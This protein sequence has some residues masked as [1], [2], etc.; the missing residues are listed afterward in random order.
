VAKCCDIVPELKAAI[1]SQVLNVSKA[2]RIVAVVQ[3]NP[4][5]WIEKARSLTQRKLEVEIA[6][7][8]PRAA[9][10]DRTRVLTPDLV[11]NRFIA[12][13]EEE[14]LVKRVIDLESQRQSRAVTRQEA[15]IIM[16]KLYLKMHDPIEKAK[17]HLDR[18]N[19]A[20]RQLC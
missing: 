6:K 5:E 20:L 8:N 11:E 14:E 1:T 4:K 19:S 16:A 10:P 18:K 13:K 7:V 15:H 3:E 9:L 12:T 17:R 2:R